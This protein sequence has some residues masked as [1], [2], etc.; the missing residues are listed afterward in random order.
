MQEWLNGPRDTDVRLAKISILGYVVAGS[1]QFFEFQQ[2]D[3]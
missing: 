3:V 2:S 1:K